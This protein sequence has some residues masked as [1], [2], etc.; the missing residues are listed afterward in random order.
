MGGIYEQDRV[1]DEEESNI[2]VL[3]EPVG[4]PDK[5]KEQEH[6]GG[7]SRLQRRG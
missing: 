5:L 3:G 6:G 1:D 7:I 2:R 4:N